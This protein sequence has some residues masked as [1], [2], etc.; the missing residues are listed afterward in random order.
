MRTKESKRPWRLVRVWTITLLALSTLTDVPT[1]ASSTTGTDSMVQAGDLATCGKYA[2]AIQLYD[3]A[4]SRR[5]LAECEARYQKGH[6]LE[7][8]GL[9]EEA[10]ACWAALEKR[11]RGVRGQ[12]IAL[13]SMASTYAFSLKR[14]ED[15]AEVYERFFR[16]CSGSPL[17]SEARYQYAGLVYMQTDFEQARR[18][19]AGFLEEW[20]DH[21]LAEQAR[22]RLTQ[23]D[24]QLA[25]VKAEADALE[26]RRDVL[27]EQEA[28]RR[29]WP[30]TK[31]QLE[32][33]TA[34]FTLGRYQEALPVFQRIV[35]GFMSSEYEEAVYRMGQCYGRIGDHRRAMEAWRNVPRRQSLFSEGRYG[36]DAD[37]AIAD[38]LLNEMDATEEAF[39]RYREFLDTQP[40]SE[41]CD[42]V[43]AQM[44]LCYL[45]EGQPDLA[46]GLLDNVLANRPARN[47]DAP[48]DRVDRLFR[49]CDNP[50][51]FLPEYSREKLSTRAMQQLRRADVHFTGKDYRHAAKAYETVERNA[52]GTESA[53]YALMQAGRCLNQMSAYY[54]ALNCYR[55]FLDRYKDS[56][57]ADDA[58][59]RAGVVYVG[60]LNQRRKGLDLFKLIL[61]RY[62]AG[63]E[64][65]TAQMHLVTLAV[66]DGRLE[67][68]LTLA[69]DLLRLYPDC[70][71][72]EFVRQ[73]QLPEIQAALFGKKAEQGANG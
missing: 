50:Q 29:E 55:E 61:D 62:P 47:A 21:P 36:D 2:D 34:L 72:A 54:R 38:T 41:W 1:H 30:R 60:P 5:G 58:L 43:R 18:L 59:L 57:L 4:I 20:P 51:A 37:V 66:W 68:A 22:E 64:A 6:C 46:R 33:A 40:H 13:L 12:D 45:L 3:A 28:Q 7:A 42:H 15:A 24:Q 10:I 65:P 23:C 9:F 53:A 70:Q 67:E 71:Y 32:E 39:K 56:E 16:K 19:F 25:R 69:D 26:Q 35:R 31:V 63:N 27:K 49:A 11:S 8:Q 52:A 48:L 17:M 73:V 14:F 44:A